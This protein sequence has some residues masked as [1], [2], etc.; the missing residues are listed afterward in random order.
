MFLSQANFG[1]NDIESKMWNGW[2]CSRCGC[3]SNRCCTSKS[4]DRTWTAQ[5]CLWT[6]SWKNNQTNW[7]H[8]SADVRRA[9]QS[10]PWYSVCGRDLQRCHVD[11]AKMLQNVTNLV[12]GSPFLDPWLMIVVPKIKW[13]HIPNCKSQNDYSVHTIIGLVN[14]PL[15]EILSL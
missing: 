2:N 1:S 3:D 5:D 9:S 10:N 6:V 12:V 15:I 11:N 14:H 4:H 7:E 8:Y 13:V